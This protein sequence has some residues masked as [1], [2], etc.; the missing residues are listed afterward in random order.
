MTLMR[1]FHVLSCIVRKVAVLLHCSAL[2]CSALLDIM[3]AGSREPGDPITID[4]RE[5]RGKGRN[6]EGRMELI[7]YRSEEGGRKTS[8]DRKTLP[9]VHRKLSQGVKLFLPKYI[10]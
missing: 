9:R 10:F 8:R 6:K 5:K 2:F 1:A 7:G 4:Q 3:G